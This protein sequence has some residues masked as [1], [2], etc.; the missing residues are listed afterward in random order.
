MDGGETV[1]ASPSLGNIATTECLTPPPFLCL[2]DFEHIEEASPHFLSGYTKE[3]GLVSYE[4]NGMTE[5]S[6][7]AKYKIKPAV[8]PAPTNLV[9]AF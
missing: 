7:F 9:E 1:D 6:L 2:Q 3:G 5:P 4:F 8:R